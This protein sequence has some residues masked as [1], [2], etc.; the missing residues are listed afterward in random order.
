MDDHL[1]PPVSDMLAQTI[2]SWSLQVPPK[3][4]IKLAFETV[5]DSIEHQIFGL[6]PN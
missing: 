4:E 5:Q 3:E 6:H 2:D 1:S